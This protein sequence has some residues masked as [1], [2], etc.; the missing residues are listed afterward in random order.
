MSDSKGP[1]LEEAIV[2]NEDGS[3]EAIEAALSEVE[4]VDDSPKVDVTV[5]FTENEFNAISRVFA[6][7]F[8]LVFPQLFFSEKVNE[9]GIESFINLSEHIGLSNLMRLSE[10]EA[11]DLKNKLGKISLDIFKRKGLNVEDIVKAQMQVM[12]KLGFE[13]KVTDSISGEV[14]GEAVQSIDTQGPANGDTQ[15]QEAQRG[16]EPE[17]GPS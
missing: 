13:T 3:T 10:E 6:T 17:P 4:P 14:Y 1:A 8:M 7:T 16:S 9:E 15:T 11:R 2:I 12:S 5:T